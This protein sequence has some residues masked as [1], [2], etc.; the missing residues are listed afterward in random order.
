[1]EKFRVIEGTVWEIEAETLEQ[2]QAIYEAHF[3]GS[4][5]ELPM[6][7]VEGSAYWYGTEYEQG[8]S[9]AVSELSEVF[10]GVEDTDL[11]REYLGK[12]GE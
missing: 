4:E 1:M 7:E 5:D 12:E 2:A 11:G 10:E 8:A 3:N 6:R 9:D